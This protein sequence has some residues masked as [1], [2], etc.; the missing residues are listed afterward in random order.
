MASASSILVATPIVLSFVGC[1]IPLQSNNAGVS[2]DGGAGQPAAGQPVDDAAAPTG[3]WVDVTGNL[4]VPVASST[5][6]CGN[7]DFVSLRQY[8]GALI[9][10]VRSSGLWVDTDGTSWVQLGNTNT[11]SGI[12][13]SIVYDP[14]DP[15]IVWIT[16]IYDTTGAVY[17]A[18]DGS[19][20]SPLGNAHHIEALSIDF[21][22]PGR[23]TLVAGGHEQV[24]KAY[25]WND[26]VSDWDDIGTTIPAEA[27]NS[28]Y[29]VVIDPQTYLIGCVGWG[30]TMSG[31]YRTTDAGK[32]WALAS[33]AGGRNPPLIASS[34]AIYW[35]GDHEG[36]IAKSTDHGAHWTQIVGQGEVVA[37][38]TP[39]EL[40]D[41]RLVTLSS[42]YSSQQHVVASS[43]DGAT[44]KRLSVDVPFHP[45]GILYDVGRKAF[46]IWFGNCAANGA[47]FAIGRYDFDYKRM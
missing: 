35:A 7:L 30:G 4:A 15:N 44:W 39:V 13:S 29:P 2:S 9:A 19:T 24:R 8:D 6:A 17:K 12:P 27:N 41:G 5:S 47:P 18:T 11:I 31:I 32:S 14:K 28:S 37:T 38:V 3:M 42:V 22:D 43:D 33:D 21:T 20:F 46:Y 1:V 40:P 23:K 16:S 34:G 25:R 26:S 36:N 45:A 10:G